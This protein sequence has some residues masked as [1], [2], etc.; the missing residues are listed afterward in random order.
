MAKLELFFSKL[1][2]KLKDYIWYILF[3]VVMFGLGHFILKDL[4]LKIGVIL[5]YTPHSIG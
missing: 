5:K 3:L 4:I 1:Y 2:L